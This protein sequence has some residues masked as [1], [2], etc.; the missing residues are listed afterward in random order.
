MTTQAQ[1]AAGA[2]K[3]AKFRVE[4]VVA[5]LG[6]VVLCT[7]I[8]LLA[9]PMSEASGRETPHFA[10]DAGADPVEVADGPRCSVAS[11]KQFKRKPTTA[12]PMIAPVRFASL[13]MR[14]RNVSRLAC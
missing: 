12:S 5:L 3:T 13:G 14:R 11:A 1:P 10:V 7:D 2:K 4:S 8:R 9:W 6:L